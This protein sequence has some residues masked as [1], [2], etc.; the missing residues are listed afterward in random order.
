MKLSHN[1]KLFL[2]KRI[3][4]LKKQRNKFIEQ[5]NK[6]E[7]KNINKAISTVKSWLQ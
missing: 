1:D 4:H 5:K 2:E 6:I 7:V 3:S